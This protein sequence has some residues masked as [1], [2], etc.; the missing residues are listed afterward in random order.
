[1]GIPARIELLHQG[2]EFV[3]GCT[4]GKD[5]ARGLTQMIQP[6]QVQKMNRIRIL[7]QIK[8]NGR[9]ISH[10]VANQVW[11]CNQKLLFPESRIW[12]T[13]ALNM[14]LHPRSNYVYESALQCVLQCVLKSQMRL[15]FVESD[16]TLVH[17]LDI[18]YLKLINRVWDGFQKCIGTQK[19]LLSKCK[20]HI[21][22]RILDN[23]SR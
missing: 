1:V 10:H 9:K 8:K 23:L 2:K 3:A 14:P 4:S 18:P 13:F 21:L 22:V 5:A 12:Q 17:L 19:R 15:M 11:N 6:K 7:Y 20:H 16:S